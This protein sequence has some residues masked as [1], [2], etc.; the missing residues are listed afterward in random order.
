[1]SGYSFL[2]FFD[3]DYFSIFKVFIEFVT[4]LLLFYVLVFWPQGM[5]DPS[6][7]TRDQTHTPCTG[8]FNQL[9]G[10]GSLVSGYSCI[11]TF[12]C[13]WSEVAA[14]FTR[15]TMSSPLLWPFL[16]HCFTDPLT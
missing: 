7:P 13:G 3:V 15:R 11:T 8:N 2:F 5:W 6:S 16:L 1:M 14:S 12:S 9:G 4:I 10:Q